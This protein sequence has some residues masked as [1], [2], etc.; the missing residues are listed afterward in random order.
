[1]AETVLQVVLA[2]RVKLK[3][4]KSSYVIDTECDLTLVEES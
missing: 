1:M 4:V 3:L 2:V